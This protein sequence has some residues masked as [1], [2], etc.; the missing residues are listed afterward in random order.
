M[1]INVSIKN[2]DSGDKGFEKVMGF[3]FET[4]VVCY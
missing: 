2:I 3:I 4:L 1:R